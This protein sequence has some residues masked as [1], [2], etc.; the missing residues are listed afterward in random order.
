MAHPTDGVGRPNKRR[1]CCTLGTGLRES[2]HLAGEH[3][4]VA[5]AGVARMP[6]AAK[7][8]GLAI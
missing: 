2:V 1:L 4:G 8:E 5:A 6:E 3:G 7:A